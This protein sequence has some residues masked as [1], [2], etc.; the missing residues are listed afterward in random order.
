[1]RRVLLLDLDETLIEEEP[2][3]IEAFEATAGFAAARAGADIPH[4]S[5]VTAV[6][7]RARELWRSSPYYDYCLAI[8]ISST[9]GL[10][11]RFEGREAVTRGLRA[12]VTGYR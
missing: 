2:A 9:E 8:G 10:W 11:C 7:R 5:L 12:W 6:R 4:H 3:A 1:M